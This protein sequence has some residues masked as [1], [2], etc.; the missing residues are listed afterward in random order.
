MIDPSQTRIK[1]QPLVEQ[2]KGSPAAKKMAGFCQYV[3]H[4]CPTTLFSPDAHPE[5]RSMTYFWEL[6]ELAATVDLFVHKQEV[7]DSNNVC[8][9]MP[10]V[11]KNGDFQIFSSAVNG[12]NGKKKTTSP[13]RRD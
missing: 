7:L 9:K 11:S 5:D 8:S 13:E 12:K 4:L 2:Y 6:I 1:A 3:L 10:E